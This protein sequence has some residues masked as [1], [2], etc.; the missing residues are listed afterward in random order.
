MIRQIFVISI[1]LCLLC[2]PAI[3]NEIEERQAIQNHV[4]SL[5]TNGRFAELDEL[6]TRYRETEERTASGVWK[7]TQ[8]YLAFKNF[9][10][11]RVK[12][13]VYWDRFDILTRDYMNARPN[14]PTA[15]IMRARYFDQY[16]WKFRGGGYVNTVPPDAWGPFFKN[17]RNAHRI[18]LEG[19]EIADVDPQWYTLRAEIL[20]SRN[21][22]PSEFDA[23]LLEGVERFPT[24]YQLW[25][26]VMEY[27]SP[28][29]HGDAEK[30]EALA[31][32]AVSLTQDSESMAIYARIYWHAG[33]SYYPAASLFTQSDID[34]E[35]MK[36]GINDVLANYPAQWNIQNFA[37]FA[38]LKGDREFASELLDQMTGDP[39]T[40]VSDMAI[41][42]Q[43][44][45]MN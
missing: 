9:M 26:E 37:R 4:Q 28:R 27:L 33:F 13:E 14:S 41:I 25:Y 8:I 23:N 19:R 18:L 34:W 2:N 38:C 20:R 3:S 11:I 7:L 22:D 45:Q 16:A 35:Q 40:A 39:F 6:A 32:Y 30:I 17:V 12:E 43:I 44:C 29:W 5:L 36:I 10:D 21:D 31:N 15:I 24:Y 1:F 42:F